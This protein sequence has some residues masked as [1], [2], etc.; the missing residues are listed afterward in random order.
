MHLRAG[1]A[2]R[3]VRGK[4]EVERGR[5]TP[6]HTD[7]ADPLVVAA[8]AATGTNAPV[9]FGGVSDL[10]HVRDVPGIVLGPGLP[11]QS[12]VA[13]EWIAES[14]VERAVGVYERL[15]REYLR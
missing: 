13:D 10:F 1:G 4:I 2:I 5:I 7:V 11:E 3:A 8:L 9:G 12:H 6:V 15:A 14:A